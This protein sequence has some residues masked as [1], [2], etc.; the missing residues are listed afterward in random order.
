M[1]RTNKTSTNARIGVLM[2]LMAVSVMAIA[3]VPA[4]ALN[5]ERHY[6]QVSPAYKGGFGVPGVL[7]LWH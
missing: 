2:A 5:P 1:T 4:S 3:A 6:E 7:K